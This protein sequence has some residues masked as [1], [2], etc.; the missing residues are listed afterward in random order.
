MGPARSWQTCGR[1]VDCTAINIRTMLLFTPYKDV[2]TWFTL[3]EAPRASQTGLSSAGTLRVAQKSLFTH[4]CWD[5]QHSPARS[6]L[7]SP[8]W[9][10][11]RSKS[12][13]HTAHGLLQLLLGGSV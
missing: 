8:P 4:T 11:I 7:F 5:W 6:K 1:E 10:F 2:K 9:Q 12:C 13:L 3:Q